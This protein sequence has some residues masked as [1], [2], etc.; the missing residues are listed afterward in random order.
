M[1]FAQYR[2]ES[3]RMGLVPKSPLVTVIIPTYN[4]SAVLPY[5]IDSVLRQTMDD[6]ELLVIGDGCT[7]DSEMVV[8]SIPDSRVRW[9]NLP[10]N[11]GHQA[12]PNNRG[13]R[14]ARGEFIAY[15]GH[16]DIWLGHH[17]ECMIAAL[18][19][20]GAAVAY[21]LLSRIFP[22]KSVGSPVFP[23]LEGAGGGTPSCT[24]YRRSVTDRIGGWG[25]Y[26][27]L[28]LPP[29]A[30][31]FSR[32]Q[33]AGFATVFVPRLTAIKFPASAR[34][35][36]YRDKPS[37]EQAWW[38]EKIN[39]RPDF[40]QIHLIEMMVAGEAARAMPARNLFRILIEEVIKR[41]VWR[42]RRKS[43]LNAMFWTA[44]GGGIEHVR[45]YKGL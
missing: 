38:F 27:E 19:S 2:V 22:G 20:S 7:D 5:S 14:E 26:R 37:H 43:G 40:E 33:E 29:D 11:T 6:F 30:D 39:S 16:D 31:L 45:K 3:E 41:L 15:L 4:W 9:I 24:V 34:K 13:L 35:N 23:G 12:G 8:T 36:V 42:L 10:S 32:A 21:S 1:A 44:K 18:E 28:R 17:L 25:D